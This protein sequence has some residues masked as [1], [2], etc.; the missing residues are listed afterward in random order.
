MSL[1]S[2]KASVPA[3]AWAYL[4]H[5][6]VAVTLVPIAILHRGEA[7]EGSVRGVRLDEL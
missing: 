1:V 2:S 7:Q 6:Q 3:A 5:H 4:I